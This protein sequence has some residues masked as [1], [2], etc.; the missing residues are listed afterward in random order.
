MVTIRN[1]T[2]LGLGFPK[3]L[4]FVAMVSLTRDRKSFCAAILMGTVTANNI[5]CGRREFGGNAHWQTRYTLRAPIG[6]QCP[7]TPSLSIWTQDSF[8]KIWTLTSNARCPFSRYTPYSFAGDLIG[9]RLALQIS[10]GHQVLYLVLNPGHITFLFISVFKDVG[11]GFPLS[12]LVQNLR[13]PMFLRFL[14]FLRK[15]I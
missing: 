2:L 1:Y 3:E 5:S 15:I 7:P 9:L 14:A 13:Q 11:Q 12:M 8:T 6:L 4:R 10:W